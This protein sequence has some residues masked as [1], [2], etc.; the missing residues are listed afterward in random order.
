MKVPVL[1]LVPKSI[2]DQLRYNE[3]VKAMNRY[4]EVGQEIP[5]DWWNELGELSESLGIKFVG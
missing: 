5:E 3:I 1:G 4:T 2:H